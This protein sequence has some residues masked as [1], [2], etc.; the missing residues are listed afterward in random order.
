M[1]EINKIYNRNCFDL[2]PEIEDWGVDLIITDPPYETTKLKFDV[3]SNIDWDQFYTEMRRVLKPNGRFF[4][5][6]TLEMYKKASDYFDEQ[7]TYIWIKNHFALSSQSSPKPYK[8]HEYLFCF[9]QKG[10]KKKGELTFHRDELRTYGHK[11]Y[12]AKNRK[13]KNDE[14][15]ESI[16]AN[17]IIFPDIIDRDWRHGTSLLEYNMQQNNGHPT[18]KPLEMVQLLVRGYSNPNDI[19]LDP[20]IGSGTTAMACKLENRNYIGMEINS[21]YYDLATKRLES[22]Q[23]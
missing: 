5:F 10:L 23:V 17:G 12:S 19:I 8:K 6:G 11:S 15:A 14:Y 21:K 1:L 7:F 2:L 16:G 3:E 13:P 9:I 22:L 20:F 18:T 4:L